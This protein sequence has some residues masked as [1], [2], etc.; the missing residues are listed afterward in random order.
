MWR[1]L[2]AVAALLLTGAA[3]Y[4]P[5]QAMRQ[6][7]AAVWFG[8]LTLTDQAGRQVRLYEDLMAGNIVIVNAFY[9]GCRASCPQV[10]GTLSNL[11]GQLEIDGVKARFISITVDP[12]HDTPD[13]LALYARALGADADWRM[14][15]GDPV[16]VR[17]A[18]HKFGLDTN[19]DDPGDH[20]NVLYIANLR[21]G[22]WEKVFSLAP[23]E[24][25]ERL[26]REVEADRGS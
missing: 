26:L 11:R 12:E 3:D 14:L 19:P 23:I 8:Q 2:V 6:S 15:S 24:D 5:P 18:L 10:M 4:P 21:T 7:G 13:R 25:L 16:T 9:T 1:C 17:L 20:L 22:L